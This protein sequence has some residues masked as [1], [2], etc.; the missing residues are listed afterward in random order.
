[1]LGA[2]VGVVGAGRRV[3]NWWRSFGLGLCWSRGL[4]LDCWL[5]GRMSWGWRGGRNRIRSRS[6]F[7]FGSGLGG[8]G[9]VA[10]VEILIDGVADGIAPC[11]GAESVYEFVLGEMEGLDESL[12]EVGEGL[13][14][15]GFD[16]APSDS[17][18][19]AGEA[20]AEIAGGHIVSGEEIG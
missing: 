15:F 3:R 11:F 7:W 6:Y 10:I 1:M 9:R 12:G 19:E 18:E 17:G 8:F 2:G 4:G 14:G 16:L 20:S 5:D 13:S